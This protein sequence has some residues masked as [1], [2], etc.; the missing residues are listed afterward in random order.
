[1]GRAMIR[2]IAII[3]V[4]IIA[5]I[6]VFAATK[7][8]NF[9]VQRK[10]SIK[11]P[12]DKIYASLSNFKDWGHWSPWEE[13]DPQMKRVFSGEPSG[14]GA[15]YEWDGNSEVGKGRMEIVEATAPSQ[16]AI[17]LN[18]T[19]P[20]EAEN[21]A[22]FLLQPNADETQVTWAMSGKSNFFCKVM[23]VFMSM[24]EMV[25]KDFEAGLLKLKNLAE[26]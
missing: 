1:M 17:K 14:K 5:A 10:A 18:F 20:F 25:G 9:L 2:K 11:A 22:E 26:K 19:S 15:V 8:D 21:R 3:L 23:G 12:A 7:P 4:V 13:K 16:L 6:L 24:D